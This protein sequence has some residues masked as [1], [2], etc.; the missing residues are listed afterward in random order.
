MRTVRE[1][2]PYRGRR[3]QAPALRFAMTENLSG[4]MG[5]RCFRKHTRSTAG[6]SRF[7]SGPAL[8]G[9]IVVHG[10]TQVPKKEGECEEICALLG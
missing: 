2:G 8:H 7:E 9:Y 1:A 3:E 4:D 5:R 6:G 10:E